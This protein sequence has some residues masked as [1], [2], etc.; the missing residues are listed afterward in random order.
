MQGGTHWTHWSIVLRE[1]CR[2]IGAAQGA[3]EG[4]AEGAG[5]AEDAGARY[6]G[7]RGLKNS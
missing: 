3:A 2:A 5:E 6:A 4:A 7:R 1:A